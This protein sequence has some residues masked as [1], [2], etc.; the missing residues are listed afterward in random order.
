LN[1]LPSLKCCQHPQHSFDYVGETYLLSS[2][3][4]RQ[5]E[6]SKESFVC[7]FILAQPSDK[8]EDILD[9]EDIISSFDRL[10]SIFT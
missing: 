5:W 4:N 1:F 6:Q 7:G 2:R 9:H 8:E 3:G 10:I